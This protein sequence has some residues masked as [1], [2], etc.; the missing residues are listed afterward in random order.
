MSDGSRP[1]QH[2][3]CG[4]RPLVASLCGT[5][6]KPEMQSLYRQIANLKRFSN[7]VF[8]EQV[9]NKDL[10]PFSPVV[11]MTK[12]KRPKSRGNFVL[13]FWYKHIINHW[14]PPRKITSERPYY[15]YNLNDLLTSR[16][17]DVAHV[18]YGHKAVKYLPMLQ[19]WG[20]PWLVSF[21]GVDVIKFIE[22]E[23][24]ADQLREV[25]AAASLVLARSES[26]LEALRKL[27][28]PE[29]KLR[30]NRTPIP[31]ESIPFEQRRAP[32]NQH[33]QLVQAC[34]LIAKKGLFT[35]LAAL[36]AV[37]ERFPNLKFVVCGQGPQEREFRNRILAT[38]LEKHVEL[39]G[40]QSQEELLKRYQESHVFLHPS[41]FTR[42]S[43]QEG[44]PNSML[45]AMA[46]GLPV[47]ATYHGGIPE[48]VTDGHDGILV[49]E[50]SPDKLAAA[51][52]ELLSDP[53]MLSRLSCN[54]AESVRSQF[55][56]DQQIANLENCYLEAMSKP[57]AKAN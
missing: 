8:A 13:R 14:P 5:Y 18:Y 42:S 26:L 45:E 2:P 20:G 34:R 23:G 12:Q 28:C 51:L 15:P 6:L 10:F 17:V 52:I 24:Y 50:K 36:P 29:C 16:G 56:F 21:H 48:A 53:E 3:S 27:G 7:V 37:I 43:D 25:F 46:N 30:L 44:V 49:P 31:L 55:G 22:R 19:R 38:G 35:T 54:A 11:K 57:R 1:A 32:D 47:V 33:W 40:W 9:V 41:E 4:K 39:A